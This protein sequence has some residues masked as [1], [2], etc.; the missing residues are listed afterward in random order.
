MSSKTVALGASLLAATAC[1][2]FESRPFFSHSATTYGCGPADGPTMVIV[3]AEKPI[4]SVPPPVPYV[5]MQLSPRPDTLAGRI[6]V[7]TGNGQMSAQYF[8]WTGISQPASSG[9]M[10]ITS[11]DSTNAVSGVVDLEFPGWTVTARFHAPQIP[12]GV[13]CN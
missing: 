13:Y 7:I 4:Q 6:F 2:L 12:N 1:G 11:V 10:A 8:P 3:L 5:I 9:S